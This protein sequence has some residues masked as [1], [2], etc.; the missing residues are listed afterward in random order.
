M[1]IRQKT[2]Y[3]GV[4]YRNVRR[5]GG[6]LER[7]YYIVF[8]KGGK[9]I[10]E[11]TGR[12]FQDDMTPAKAARIRSERME[13]RR[14]SRKEIKQ[15]A[16]IS[17]AQ[18]ITA[19]WDVFYES[20][21]NNKSIRDDYYR[22]RKHLES[23]FGKKR[24]SDLVT[25]D[26]DR[27]RRRLLK[28]GLAP[29]TVKQILVLL[30]RIINYGVKR[31]FCS[32]IDPSRLH[33]EMPLVNN[34]KTEDLTPNQ[35]KA[36]LKAIDED[37]HPQ[38]GPMMKMVLFTG[39]RR[40]ELHRLKWDHVDY[41]NG[42]ILLEDPKGS[43]DQKIPL[44][45]AARE[46]LNN[47]IHLGSSYVF[48][49]RNGQQ[50]VTIAKPVKKIKERAGLPKDFRPLHGLRHV[51]ASMMASSG[52]V[53]IYTLQRLLTHKDPKMTMRYAHLRDDALKRASDVAS[54][55]IGE[56]AKAADGK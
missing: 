51:Y 39:M 48:P 23:P 50:R 56:L 46:L 53:D 16:E 24:P 44:N 21:Q 10:E 27:L 43:V 13:G 37:D 49:S 35:L 54:D 33:F 19:L 36:L 15:E 55:I 9:T 4:Y 47:H 12:Q 17:Q 30:K 52:K 8:K 5:A 38:A 28:K 7:V 45:D 18:T 40:G 22:W 42:F 29:A 2:K 26:I 1:T 32:A 14:K 6:G 34:L 41:G 20:K 31:G 11:K 25:L 3:P